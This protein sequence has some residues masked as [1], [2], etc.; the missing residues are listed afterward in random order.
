MSLRN[1]HT[2]IIATIGPASCKRSILKEMLRAGVSVF[3]LNFSHGTHTEHGRVI[4]TL[5]ELG[6]RSGTCFAIVQDLQGPKIR[7]GRLK[8]GAALLKRGNE[9]VITTRSVVGDSSHFSISYRTFPDDV[10]QGD[11]VLLQDGTIELKV[12]SKDD[13]AVRC[14]V[15]TGGLLGERAGVNLPGVDVSSAALTAKDRKD[16]AFGIKH[17]VDYIALSFVRRASDILL[18]KREIAKLGA[19]VPVIAKIE[20]PEAVKH[21]NA[22]LD[23]SD[24]VMVARGDLAVETSLARVPVLQKHIIEMANRVGKPC[25]TA[26]Q[27][28]E[29]MAERPNPSRAE[30]SDVANAVYDGTDAVM[31]SNETSVG[32]YPIRA[33]KV[34]IRIIKCAERDILRR[35]TQLIE[36]STRN[37]AEATADAAC[38]AAIE[39]SAKAIIVFTESGLTARRI[40][41]RRPPARIIAFSPNESVRRRLALV[42]GVIPLPIRRARNT[43]QLLRTAQSAILERH[44]L[45]KGDVVVT[46]AGTTSL[47]GAT[48]VMKLHRIGDIT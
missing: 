23:A 25:I 7:V 3:R 14:R 44:M 35:K 47:S 2:K 28:L 21:L 29:S 32:K 8:D 16:L 27:M 17:G 34:M 42:W 18:L 48:N 4:R 39:L 30:A 36:M 15:I 26:T 41:M 46:V 24:A 9:V 20:K 37:F 12:L 33:V 19:D 10:K 22:I 31:L 6:R 45:R 13:G 11:R 43:E 40:A 38:S 1:F 5:R